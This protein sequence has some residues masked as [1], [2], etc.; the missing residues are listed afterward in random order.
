MNLADV[1]QISR[2][3]RCVVWRVANSLPISL[4]NAAKMS[5]ALSFYTGEY[6]RWGFYEVG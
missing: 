3:P 2:V 1:A 4:F 5:H 6:Y